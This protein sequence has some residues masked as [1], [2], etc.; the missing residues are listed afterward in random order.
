M[1]K[2]TENREKQKKYTRN[3]YIELWRFM[4]CLIIFSFHTEGMFIS[5]WIF[6][7]FFFMLSGYFAVGYFVQRKGQLD[8]NFPM[9]YVLRRF[10]KLLPYTTIAILYNVCVIIWLYQLKGK[11][12]WLWLAY[13]PVN[14]LLLPGTGAMP[15]GVAVTETLATGH[16]MEESLWYICAMMVALPIMLYVI[17][18]LKQKFDRFLFTFLPLLLY[19]YLILSDGTIHG[20]HE[21]HL[22]FFAVDIRAVAGLL[23]GGGV[24]YFSQWWA[25]RGYTL[26]GKLVLTIVELGSMAMVLVLAMVTRAPYDITEILLLALSLSLMLSQ[27]TFTAHIRFRVFAYLGR[28]SLPIY[29]FHCTTYLMILNLYPEESTDTKRLIT[30]GIVLLAAITADMTVSGGRRF[31]GKWGGHIKRLFVLETD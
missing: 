12:L 20:W 14:I 23:M 10:T 31:L 19:G 29:C 22:T 11:E 18:Y 17:M 28:L 9:S 6:V 25:K 8:K 24:Y 26:L 1:K 30:F 2:I 3:S 5:G 13:L 7:E 27:K 4:A 16:M 15:A 21:Q